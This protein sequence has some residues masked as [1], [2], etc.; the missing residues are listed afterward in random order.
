[1]KKL[2]IEKLIENLGFSGSK[3]LVNIDMLTKLDISKHDVKTLK[4]IN[5]YAIYL[6]NSKPFILFIESSFEEKKL[7]QISKLIWN[8]QIPIAFICDSNSVKIFN[9]KALDLKSYLIEEIYNQSIEDFSEESEFSYLKISDPLFW[10][11]Y[12]KQ[13]TKTHL[14][15]YLLDNITSLTNKLKKKYKVKFATKLVLRLIFIR[16]LIDRGVDIAYKNFNHDI[17][18]SQKEL[19]KITKNKVELYELFKYL[20]EKFNG[21]LFEL[22]D[23]INNTCLTDEVFILLSDFL[24]GKISI[25]N[26]QMSLFS[27]YDFNII[28]VELISNIYEILLGKEIRN[29]DNAFYTPNYLAEYILDKTTLEFLK[30]NRQYKILDPSCGSGVF[31]VNSF[32]RI[33]DMNLGDKLF[34]EDDK[35]LKELLLSNIYGI[36]INEDAIDVTI[37]SLYLTILDYKDPKIL[38]EFKLPN[39]KGCNL[40]A[41]D[42]FDDNKL[43]SLKKINFDFIIGNPPWGSVS[44]GLHLD[45]CNKN[46]YNDMQQNKEI[47]RSFIFRAKDFSSRNTVCSFVVHSKILYTQKKPSKKFREFLLKKSQIFSVVEMSSVRKL[48]FKN[49][50]APAAVISFKYNESEENLN[51]RIIY[52]SLKPN[53]FFKL[54]NIIV[55]EKYDV[56]YISQKLLLENDWAWKTIVYGFSKDIDIIMNIKKKYQTVNEIILKN[57]F[58][59]GTGIQINGNESHDATHL[60]G[61]WYVDSKK[62]IDSFYV[63]INKGK[64]LTQDKMRRP[65]ANQQEIFI[66]PYVLLKKGVD[67]KTYRYRAAFSNDAFVYSDAVTG[68]CGKKDNLTTLYCLTG[69]LNSSFYSY[70]NIMLGTSIGIE[71][72]QGFSTE[73]FTYPAI[74]SDEIANLVVKIQEATKL[75]KTTMFLNEKNSCKYIKQLDKLILKSFN[76]NDDKFIDYAINIQ[77]PELTNSK[78]TNIYRKITKED[79]INYSECFKEQFSSIYRR[80]GKSISISVYPKILNRFTVF[81][82]EVT[83]EKTDRE[84][85]VKAEADNN[86]ELFTKIIR[87]DYNDVFH[88]I[89]DIIHFGENSFYIIKP[90]C[91][92]YWHPAIAEMDLADVLDQ[93]LSD[94][95]GEE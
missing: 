90:N 84:I 13:Y 30:N 52:T 61:K 55:I 94:T 26:G 86:M 78:S 29:K 8:A 22:N 48:V 14:N 73:I 18:A 5:P 59:H 65:K 1:M 11:Q 25:D 56:K 70:L 4:V 42:F 23:E 93:I 79:L 66:P 40:I 9:G 89:R 82:L 44:D 71:R 67:T 7:Q 35:L 47:S 12:T 41:S 64:E 24:S 27:M 95:G 2:P 54:F 91:Y 28:P 72:E 32:R 10:D 80:V 19:L 38:S 33:I 74:E 20:K 37:F 85:M 3:N 88:Q 43:E 39:L 46:G 17:K 75:E 50:D 49:A 45:Y 6:V 87:Y 68:I 69:M 16:Y 36:D 58:V 77:I 60:K 31:L 21:N 83:D 57:S 34:C 76:L 92:K 51:N 15:D 63:D 81:E 53:V 62:G